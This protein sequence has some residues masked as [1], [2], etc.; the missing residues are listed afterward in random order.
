MAH[1]VYQQA[2]AG[3]GKEGHYMTASLG[4]VGDE[5]Q[6]MM[7][8]QPYKDPTNPVQVILLD[9]RAHCRYYLCTWIPR[10]ALAYV[11]ERTSCSLEP[12]NCNPYRTLRHRPMELKRNP[13]THSLKLQGSS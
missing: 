13:R 3:R 11:V 8:V 6:I 2:R 5:K 4:H 1:V 12:H 9:F 7:R 10:A